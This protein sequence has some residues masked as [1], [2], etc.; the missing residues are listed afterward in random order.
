MDVP[1]VI[2]FYHNVEMNYTSKQVFQSLFRKDQCY[3]ILFH[4][5]PEKSTFKVT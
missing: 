2:I 3:N 4:L 5:T 1:K